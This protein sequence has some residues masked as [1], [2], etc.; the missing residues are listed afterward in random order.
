MAVTA[1]SKAAVTMTQSAAASPVTNPAPAITT[2]PAIA[3]AATILSR[4]Q[5]PILCYHQIRD[6]KYSD[7]KATRDYIV[8]TDS[9]SEQMQSLADS[10]YHTILPDRAL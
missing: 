8:P 4:P 3:D 1:D 5:V 9:F 7:S 2:T 10:G 6:Y